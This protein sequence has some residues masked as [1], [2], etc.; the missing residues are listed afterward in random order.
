MELRILVVMQHSTPRVKRPTEN[1]L[2]PDP[3]NNEAASASCVSEPLQRCRVGTV[4]A[5]TSAM[6]SG[7]GMKR[8]MYESVRFRFTH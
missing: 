1:R 4:K 6:V 5:V 7:L 2:L 3:P 8:F